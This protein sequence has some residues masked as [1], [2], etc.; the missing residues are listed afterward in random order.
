MY[1]QGLEDAFSVVSG[2]ACSS[3]G[4]DW[5]TRLGGRGGAVHERRSRVEHEIRHQRAGV[6]AQEHLTVATYTYR[7]MTGC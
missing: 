1:K 5:R 4:D 6:L 3:D 2:P 7:Y